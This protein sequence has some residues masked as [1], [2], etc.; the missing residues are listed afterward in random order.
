MR[1]RTLVIN[2]RKKGKKRLFILLSVVFVVIQ[3]FATIQTASV[4]AKLSKLE[5]DEQELIKKNRLLSE[6]LALSSS[7]AATNEFAKENGFV[8]A[9]IYIIR[10]DEFVARLP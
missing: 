8:S 5:R 9:D 3:I 4:G 1:K 6:E 10:T 7:Y 2:G